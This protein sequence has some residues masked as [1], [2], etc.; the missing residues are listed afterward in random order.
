MKREIVT[1]WER[2]NGENEAEKFSSL[3]ISTICNWMEVAGFK[4][5]SYYNDY[6]FLEI[7][8]ESD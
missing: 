6:N 5:L 8:N 7:E 1:C 2:W 3:L 4:N